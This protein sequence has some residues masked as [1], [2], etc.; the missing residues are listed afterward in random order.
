LIEAKHFKIHHAYPLI[1]LVL[2]WSI[3]RESITPITI[4]L[5]I[6]VSVCC[7][8]FY[9]KYMPLKSMGR[10]SIVKS[11]LYIFYVIGQVYINGIYLIR[12]I[13]T[14]AKVDIVKIKTELKDEVLKVIL[15]DSIT[16]IPGTITLEMQDSC[17][18]VLWL[19]KLNDNRTDNIDDIIKGALESRLH[20]IN[21]ASTT[22][23]AMQL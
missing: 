8:Y 1:V 4:A 10:F 6:I 15:A 22:E 18:T 3:L 2:L 16:L 11:A 12:F 23:A 20:K 9:H 5:G 14:G 21:R 13:F 17:L 7:L 19:R